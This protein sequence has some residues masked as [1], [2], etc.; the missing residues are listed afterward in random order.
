MVN[1]LINLPS[2]IVKTLVREVN[3]ELMNVNFLGLQD[4]VFDIFYFLYFD[5]L[6]PTHISSYYSYRIHSCTQRRL[7][8]SSMQ[9]SGKAHF[10]YL[11]PALRQFA[12]LPEL[13]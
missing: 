5:F 3:S 12:V 9:A 6:W 1:N 4:N 2:N 7:Q 13:Q 11:F 8:Q 10:P